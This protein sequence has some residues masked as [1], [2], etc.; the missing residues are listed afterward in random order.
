M[1]VIQSQPGFLTNR[2]NKGMDPVKK[3]KKKTKKNL[4]TKKCP[5]L[6]GFTGEHYQI[7]K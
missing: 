1:F 7:L 4:P 3:K 2:T 5:G 6:D